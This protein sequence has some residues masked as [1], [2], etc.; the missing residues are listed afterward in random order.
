MLGGGSIT[1]NLADDGTIISSFFDGL[2]PNRPANEVNLTIE[3]GAGILT[4]TTSFQFATPECP[5]IAPFTAL[6]SLGTC[7]N[8]GATKIY[9]FMNLEPP[10]NVLEGCQ[11]TIDWGDGSPFY[12]YT[13]TSNGDVPPNQAHT[14]T[15]HD[16]CYYE[17]TLIATNPGG[18]ATV[19]G[20]QKT[21]TPILAG[22]DDD[23]DG[24]GEMLLVN[25]ENGRADTIRVCEGTEAYITLQDAGTWDCDE[26]FKIY[27][28]GEI[29][30][31]DR[32]LQFVYG[33]HHQSQ[34]VENTI[35]GDVQILGTYPGTANS[36]AGHASDI[37]IIDTDLLATIINPNTI[38]DI[39]RIPPTSQYGEYM[40]VYLKNWNKCNPYTGN[41]WDGTAVWD[42][43]VIFI[44]RGPIAN[45]GS[46]FSICE[47][48]TADMDGS[49]HS[50]AV[51]A[52]WTTTGD[53][54]FSN[55][56]SP[57]NAVYTPGSSDIAMGYI[58]LVLHAFGDA[59]CPE[60]TDTVRVL[61]DPLPAEPV[62]EVSAGDADAS[63]C[64]DGVTFVTLRSSVISPNSVYRWEIDGA[65]IPGETSREI[66][67]N[68]FSQSGDYTV[69]IYGNT[70]NECPN[71]SDPFEVNIGQPA[72]V[73]AGPATATICSN[74]PYT[75]NGSYGGGASSATW[76]SNGDGTF[77]DVG[78]MTTTYMPGSGD[79]AAGTVTITLTTNDP[80]GP[81]V[82]V[83][84]NIIL[85]VVPAP[86]A[87]AGADEAICE[88]DI[89]T[90]TDAAASNYS[91]VTWTENGAGSITSGANTLTPT[92]TPGAGDAGNSVTLTLTATG[93]GPCSQVVDSKVIHIDRTPVATAGGIQLL[94]NTSTANLQ[95]NS[96]GND[97]LDN[98]SGE[99]TFINNLVWQETFAESTDG[100]TS[101]AQWSTS[102][103]TPDADTYFRSE[104][105]RMVARGTGTEGV[106]TSEVIDISAYSTVKAS[107]N[108]SESGDL[109]DADYIRIYY[110]LNGGAPQY[111]TTNGNNINDFGSRI[112][113]VTGLSGSTLQIVIRVRQN[114]SAEYHYFD[115]IVVREE[116]ASPEPVITTPSSATSGVT[117]L[118]QGDNL[119]RWSVFS[120]NNGC[121]SV[122]AVHTIRR[123]V[124]PAAAAA[125]SN[126]EECET[127][128]FTLNGNTPTNGGTG[129][130]TVSAGFTGTITDNTNPGTTV[131]GVNYSTHTFT[132]TISS[133]LGICSSSSDAMLLTRN[134]DPAPTASFDA[135]PH[136]YGAT[137]TITGSPNLGT[138]ASSV[139]THLWSGSGAAY[140][141]A[142]DVQ[143]PVFTAPSV[144]TPQDFQL[145]Y[146]VTDD[147]GCTGTSAT[148]TISVYPHV[149][150][151]TIG[152]DH[153]VCASSTT[154]IQV[155]IVGGTGP[156]T[157]VY[158]ATDI[159][160]TNTYT[161]NNYTSGQDI[162]TTSLDENTTFEL[163]SVTDANGCTATSLIGTAVVT[164]GVLPD[165]ATIAP[166]VTPLCEGVNA[167]LQI[168]IY[169]GVPPFQMDIDNGVG[170]ITVNGYSYTLDLGAALAP[171]VHDY[172]ITSIED[173]CNNFF[174]DL[175]ST[176]TVVVNSRPDLTDLSTSFC[177]DA[178]SGVNLTIDNPAAFGI[179][180]V[181]YNITNIVT[182]GLSASNGSPA[183][184]N[185]LTAN[186][187]AN[188]AWTNRT[189][190]D[191]DVVYTI[192]TVSDKGC[193]GAPEDITFTIQ[194]EPDLNVA[195]IDICSGE[196]TGITLTDVHGIAVSYNITAIDMNGLSAT[197]GTPATGNALASG[198]IADDAYLNLTGA[199]VD[200]EYTVVPVSVNGCAG[201]PEVITI[202]VHPQ[203]DLNVGDATICSDGATGITLS[204]ADGIASEYN[205]TAIN[206][207][208][209]TAS[210]GSPSTGTGLAANVIANDA[211]TNVTGAP[212]D[213][214]YSVVPVSANGCEGAEEDITVTI[215]PEPVLSNLSNTVC[216]D[217]A[218]A[219][220]LSDVDG[221]AASYNI[222]NINANGLTASGG[223]P[224]TGSGL[225]AGVIADD[226]WTNRTASDV[227]VVYTIVP[228]SGNSCAGDARTVTVTVQ[229]EPDLNVADIDICSGEA[230]GITLTDVHSIAVS[231]NITAIDMNGLSAIAG[232]P[233][234][235][236]A[237]AAGVIADDAYLNLT[238]ADVD[239]EYTVVPVSANGCAGDPEVITITV[240]PQPDLNVGDATICSDGATGITLSDVDGIASEYNI[241][242]INAN[243]LTASAGSPATGD[244]L[245]ANVIAN[246][247]WTNVTGAPVDVVYSVV[248]V[249]ANGC[250][251]VEEDIT[252][253]INPEPVLS[254]L[255]NTVC[256]DEAVAITLS[257]V[258]GIAASYNITNIN[259]NGLTASGGTPSTGSGLA[260]GVIADD[261]WTN[262][263]A[264]DVNVVYTIVPVSGNSCVG[265]ARTVTVT[266]QPEPDLNVADIDICS[267]E[268]TGITLTD[269]HSIAVSYNIT[270][271]DMN[272][273]SATAGTPATGNGLAAGVIS[274]DAYLNVTGADVDVEYTVVP[275]SAD[276]CAG[277]PEVITVTVHPEPV[278]ADLD[279][280]L[281]SG[282]ITA[283]TLSATN[284]AA[285]LFEIVAIRIDAGIT[286]SGTNATVGVDRLANAIYNDVFTNT[287]GSILTVEYD[288]IPKVSTTGCTGDMVTVI[289]TVGAEP[290]LDPNLD[291]FACSDDAISLVLAE[292]AGSV[293]PNYYN[294]ISVTIDPALVAGAGNA[295]VPE[296]NAAADYLQNDTY[297]NLT[298]INRD[299]VYRV[300]PMIAADCYGDPVDIT[301]TIRPEPIIVPGQTA[302]AC[303][304]ESI[305]ME[306]LMAPLNTPAGTTFSWPA[307][308][309]SD[310]S[311]QG[312]AQSGVAADP[313]GT[314]HITD[315]LVNYSGAPITATYYITP[316]SQY[317]C[318]GTTV[319]VVVT[320][321]PEPPANPINGRDHLCAGETSVVYTVA[322][323][324][325]STY[326]WTVPASV[327]TVIFDF[328]TNAIIINAAASA[329]SGD[330]S[331]VEINS[332]GCSSEPN[333]IT[334]EVYDPV[335]SEDV[336]GDNN[337]C[338]YETTT[339]SV[340][341]NA[342]STYSW[343]IP[344]GAAIQGDPSANEVT[345]TFGVNGGTISVRETIAAGC[346]TDH[347]PFAVTVE[348][349]P[350]AVISNG[351]IICVEGSQ[352]IQVNLSGSGDYTFVYALNGIDQP[353]ITTTDDPYTLNVNA[354]GTYTITSVTDNI[355]GCTN[356]GSGSAVVSFHPVPTGTVTGTTDIC[357]GE[358]SVVTLT[359]TGAPPFNFEYTDGVT[360]VTVTGHNSAVYT[361]TV[362]PAVTTTYTLVSLSD[363]NGCN[364]TVSG[365]AE[366]TV[367][368][369]PALNFVPDN[370]DCFGDNS[371]EIDMTVTG[372]SPYSYSWTGPSGFTA[373]TEDITGLAAGTYNVTVTDV[374]GCTS[375]A[376]QIITQPAVL[377]LSS[378]GDVALLCNGDATATGT[379]TVT[380]GTAP[381]TFTT[382]SNSAGATINASVGATIDFTGGGAG[383]VTIEVTDVKGCS[384]QAV[385]TITEPAAI[386]VSAALSVSPEGSHNIS[387]FGGNNGS[388]QL[389]VSGGTAPYV[390]AWTTVDGS[391]LN[392]ADNGTQTGL[393]AGTYNVTITDNNGCT[394]TGSYTLTEP[395][396]LSVTVSADDYVIGNCPGSEALLTGVATGGVELSGGGYIY[397]WSPAGGLGDPASDITTAKPSSTVTYT[398]TVTDANGCTASDNLQ[399]EVRPS[400]TAVAFAD[401]NIIGTCL[402]SVANLDVNVNGGEEL[403]GGGYSYS[404]SPVAG[405][406][407]AASK[408]PVAKPA[409]TTIYTVT[410]TDANGCQTTSSV[411]ITVAPDL[412]VTATVDDPLL[413][414]CPGS[415]AR[416]DATVT[417]GEG[418]YTYLWDNAATLDDPTLRNPVA[419]PL[420]PTTYTV[421]VT[422]ANGCSATNS[423]FVDVAPPLTAT[424]SADD[425]IIS[426]CPTS[427]A[428]MDVTVNG[429]EGPFTYR[430]SPTAGLSDPFSSDPV[431]KPAATTTYTVTVTDA[432][433]CITTSDVLITVADP[434]AIGHTA[435]VYNGGW[436]VSCLGEADG[437]IDITVSGGE[438]PYGFAWSGPAGFSSVDE[439]ITALAAG[440]YLLTVTDLNGCTS[441]YIVTLT[442]PAELE[443]DAVVSSNYNGK[444]ISCFGEADGSIDL[445]VAGGTAPYNYSW[446]GPA[447][448]TSTDEDPS[449][450]TAGTYNVTVTDANGCTAT[451]AV[452]LTQPDQLE[453]NPTNDQ[454]LDC[455]G[456]N[457]G[458]GTFYAM[459]GTMPYTFTEVTN[460]AG[461]TLATAGMNFLGISGASAGEVTIRVTDVNDCVAEAT[462]IFTEPDPLSPGVIGSDQVVCFDDDPVPITATTPASGGTGIYTYQWQMTTIAGG[463]YTNIPGATDA[464]YDP[465]AGATMTTW[466]RREVRTGICAPEYT[467]P[468]EIVVNPLPLALITGGGTICPGDNA[469]IRITMSQGTGPF[470]LN[471]D[472]LGIV[473]NYSS[474]V[475]LPVSPAGN[476]TY[477][478]I[479]V[480][481]AIGCVVT[482]ATYPAFLNGSATVTVR[483]N[484]V[485]TDDP[486]DVTICEYNMTGFEVTATG[487]DLIYQWEVYDGTIWSD[488]SDGG[489]YFGSQSN[490]L[491][492]F[493]ATRS[494]SGNLYR[495][496]ATTC[497]V[498]ATSAAAELI[499]ET[500][501]EIIN[502]PQ[503]TTICVG[504]DAWM[505][506]D[507]VGDGLTY[508][509]Y[510]NTGAGFVPV[511]DDGINYSGATTDSLVIMDAPSQF[512]SDLFRVVVSGTCGV[513]VYSGFSILT[514]SNPPVA[515]L[516]PLDDEICED[517]N[518]YFVANGYGMDSIRWQ[519]DDGSGWT[520][521]YDDVN[522]LGSGSPQ[523]TIID[524]PVS[525]HGNMYRLALYNECDVTYTAAATL[526]VNGNPVV[527]FST[528]DPILAC[529]GVPLL[530]NGNPTGGSGSYVS[531]RWTGQVGPLNNYFVV[532]PVF[533][534]SIQGSYVLNYAVTD[535]KTCSAEG[536]VTVE[537]ERPT[538]SFAPD[539]TSGCPDLT[540]N[541][542]D[543]SLG[544]VA[545]RWDF[546]DG[547]AIDNTA[548]DVSH[549]YTNASSSLLYY[550]VKLEVESANG[551]ID[552][553]VMGVTV[554]PEASADFTLS[555]D[556]ICAGEQVI[557]TSLP[558]AYQYHW[559]YGDGVAEYGSNVISH[560]FT[561]GSTAPVTYT[562]RLT[563]S[564]F[565][566]CDA[567]IEKDIVVYPT[568]VPLFSANPP[569]QVYPAATVIFE[570]LTA[571]PTTWDFVWK[572]D[573]GNTSTETNPV[574]TYADPGNYNVYLI[575]TNGECSDSVNRLIQVLPTP[576]IASF[577]SVPGACSPSTITLNN[578]SLY[579]TSY[580]W[581]FGDG[582]V[583]YAANPTYT[584]YEHGTYRITLTATGPGGT[585]VF[586]RL[587]E[588]YE[589][590]KAYFE[591]APSRVFVDDE[592]VRG[593]N[594]SEGADYYIWE[595]GDGDTSMVKDPYHRYMREGLYDVTLHA[596]SNNGCYN[597]FTL[598]PGVTV[599]PAGDIRFA[600]VFRP[601][602]EG[603]NGG[604]VSS[605]PADQVDIVFFPPVKDQVD[606]YKL[607]IFNRAGVLIFESNDINI[608]WDGYFNG[609]L[610]MQG[611]YVWYVEGNYANGKPYKKVGDITLLH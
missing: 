566:G 530:L 177:S 290:V 1:Y 535:S 234:T 109:E 96:G 444:N 501:P 110:R 358:S 61:L 445:T 395:P 539:V 92:Y 495:V 569:S 439:D 80:G 383:E 147:N 307:P 484:P 131:S 438:A 385:I 57:S 219:I 350:T 328:N 203:P 237:L 550:N 140:L 21:E 408:T 343:G 306:I 551:C 474:G 410:V 97:L 363:A 63:F 98:A 543:N 139:T 537:V 417:G 387:C 375:T 377:D 223:T 249:S 201:D 355:T 304:G 202:T 107:V 78:D 217:E 431:A 49:I 416:L 87:N 62:I 85:T 13:S 506:V 370:L 400:L 391:G 476:T 413:G 150:S 287:T 526:T 436:N 301:I 297:T 121:D 477:T 257:D 509:W 159:N 82:A 415:T 272:G 89:Y 293:P 73:D 364:G 578:T 247:A 545:Y 105:H 208:G 133:A 59:L 100:A 129:L 441:G 521:L 428:N 447:A 611:V 527:D 326:N 37:Y 574:H 196:A 540:I 310:G 270:A 187:L 411:T 104:N 45:A 460:T 185:G 218:V 200:V 99:W 590:P 586:S 388:I 437:A 452:T 116:A 338:A 478:L 458:Y 322:S 405:L 36:T 250:E 516:D 284:V 35:T 581:E 240:H 332:W 101:G 531:H 213:V 4:P 162:A 585:N 216:S 132:W 19:G 589:T 604:D 330:I 235:G 344:P 43:I 67:L 523:L 312:T 599:V 261:R 7:V 567:W 372:N 243:G 156:Y 292:A 319:P 334:V 212:V 83:S 145:I 194:P 544:A 252:V 503:D 76:S 534:T 182:N 596:Y 508:Q 548:G 610:C 205:I 274:D 323:H 480:E 336:T 456:D 134:E 399:I 556:T 454:L 253:T 31:A 224:S 27:P 396:A 20:L 188:D 500:A 255:S 8:S 166:V 386:A 260:A 450:L 244:G 429:G 564:S 394:F 165:R 507:A 528:I 541:F 197:A 141:S 18:C 278:L 457:D 466:Y 262:R 402:L 114:I 594:L 108:I 600:N 351:G 607:Q 68:N 17:V 191:V 16:S 536:S 518:V 305:D 265:D 300:Q 407:D 39:I 23:M 94:C 149:Q 167:Q 538:A 469:F 276:G 84:D 77:G 588:V 143:N 356:T 195:D 29:N 190:S 3:Y 485:I 546:G 425:D 331:V 238:G 226:R 127:S 557:L 333:I 592:R 517:G 532:D 38:S 268:A 482:E 74:T 56:T 128:T 337:V 14:Y 473:N 492:I 381:Y 163:V 349:L 44:E 15:N 317:G 348:P 299:V 427:V 549:T 360:P 324:A 609:R 583:S 384:D 347:N 340:P 463:P 246:D 181:T 184:G 47:N 380:G 209:L 542:T 51:S 160:G 279:K 398:L 414:D 175:G 342:G 229:P 368:E 153:S 102:G 490:N 176:A 376:S 112:A 341:F 318:E 221:I 315:A 88:S 309:M 111:F 525:L 242:A 446:T 426:S 157:V 263:T 451:T 288:I 378:S 148:S 34:S 325:G 329:G 327:G 12:T 72:V 168:Q 5:T 529:G 236:N 161:E 69:T 225:A 443:A 136:C 54:I 565:H 53:G 172:N 289:M 555:A 24:N 308:T 424:A 471:I 442:S 572:F 593:F 227:N 142:T 576:P 493:S 303:S 371:G 434:I 95:G 254:N 155:A 494:L 313:A 401:D 573:D 232:T 365:M 418:G 432:N 563:T 28:P 124:S 608:G 601:N 345:I 561:N 499:I 70:A 406:D 497:G 404:W 562:I 151:A 488:I 266:V 222:T 130:W 220:T 60:H 412:A 472:G 215:N 491:M 440:T 352:P 90:V 359:F 22:R 519:V 171:G 320:I 239:V 605:L 512:T 483:E 455:F 291:D 459:G 361:F 420:V 71:E 144:L 554:Y 369:R 393:T 373:N 285:D 389:T 515:T 241:T 514:V 103:V 449:L 2:L 64:E 138:G 214:V 314:A 282:N 228:V 122:S 433:G 173:A 115:N 553:M 298:G 475:N 281:C 245:A 58:D 587:V 579:A 448:F 33:M 9:N 486:D 598:S 113:S 248:P 311:V 251:G 146:T 269:V 346:V 277:D 183:T 366:V 354:A 198:V 258:D 510:V 487:T 30:A 321:N 86:A 170:T 419:K 547:T 91:I 119:F 75:T 46:D 597:S 233:A 568:P 522:H 498:T 169:D 435:V 32:N 135:G 41:A 461:A 48:G 353:A 40:H 273:L 154:N 533:N 6:T 230:T 339:Y 52:E 81:C 204:G 479:S 409:A 179:L 603:P 464:A 423:V 367:N 489:T 397:S 577:D 210:A 591:V 206:A 502:H 192:V 560:L 42:S 25:L 55:A 584:Y 275:V 390:Y 362:S 207:N 123:D 267:G 211:W 470:R 462:I 231:Y 65:N 264:S 117:G 382:V 335:G 571:N 79:I 283:V 152:S 180:S 505:D 66:T 271:I 392:A 10:V 552:S 357:E 504:N 93:N 280:A 465:P 120:E 513:P 580:M 403:G 137:T 524:V 559:D 606:N 582:A 189:A 558:G 421:T 11:W 50:A 453:L 302:I 496:K 294:I 256:S 422:D 118:W 174:P 430:W 125:G 199:D 158:T 106:W 467:N 296:P 26:L 374:N 186:V 379:F 295:T 602:K 520:E 286:P 126:Q 575:V 178:Q 468:V 595:W 164:V 481:D 570:N 316:E 259:A 193:T 511:T